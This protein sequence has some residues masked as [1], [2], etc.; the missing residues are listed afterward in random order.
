MVPAVHALREGVLCAIQNMTEISPSVML[1]IPSLVPLSYHQ[2]LV[3]YLR[4]H[5]PDVWQWSRSASVREEH[6]EAVRADLLRQTYRIDEV[7]H[8]A[9]HQAART[10]AS[11]LGLEVPIT[12]YQATDGLMNAALYYLPG[13]AHIVFSG[14]LLERL[15][16]PEL[17]AVLGHELSHYRLWALDDGI[18]HAGDRILNATAADPRSS[19]AHVS[20]ARLYQ[21]FTEAYADRGAVVA[22]GALEPAVT[23][24][25]KTQT[26]LTQVSAVSYLKQADEIVS[27]AGWEASGSSHPE[28]FVRARA[29]RLWCEGDAGA[30]AWLSDALRGPLRLDGVDLIGQQALARLTRRVLQQMLRP[31]CMRSEATLAHARRFFPDFE[32]AA[33]SDET[34]AADVGV[35]SACHDYVAALLMDLAL[36]DRDMEEVP[37]SAAL[38]L[39][40]AWGISAALEA[41]IQRDLK[42]TKRQ[43]NKL[44]QDAAKVVQKA[45]AAHA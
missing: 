44:N 1:D 34:L 27:R 35:A 28:V 11:R 25:V 31:P 16:G 41:R 4:E 8:P 17:V 15:Q 32:I 39:G 30:D 22:C 36:A 29:L 43:F 10:A 40:R 21:L 37:L 19:A 45:E 6:A 14:P 33:T 9:L 18:Y 20:T 3:L 12:L 5:E 7:A 23:A 42:M 26:G 2:E 24:L 13:E 38:E